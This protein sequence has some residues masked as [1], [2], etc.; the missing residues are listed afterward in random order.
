DVELLTEEM[1]THLMPAALRVGAID[2]ALAVYPDVVSELT[3]RVIRREHIVA[4]LSASHPLADANEISLEA[5]AADLVLFPRN[6]A[7]TLHDF[8]AGLCGRAGCEPTLPREPSRTRWTIGAWNTSIAVMLPESVSNDLPPG[9]VAVRISEPI[10]LL[11]NEL[12]W[13]TDDDNPA[14]AAFVELSAGVY[15]GS[16]R[17]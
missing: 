9:T 10:D 8:S 6:L 16:V 13:R 11:Q 2:V 12:V 7:P 17:V 3:Y 5:L 14:L 1:R 15:A 4:V